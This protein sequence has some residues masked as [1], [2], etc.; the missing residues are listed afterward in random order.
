[1]FKTDEEAEFLLG[2][3]NNSVSH[4]TIG[5]G[6]HGNGGARS[7]S[8]EKIDSEARA[9]IG[10]LATLFGDKAA[11]E[12]TSKPRGYAT[13]FRNGQNLAGKPDESLERELIS[14]RGVIQEK[15]LEKADQFLEMLGIGSDLSDSMK[16]ASI[17]EKVVNI[18]E[19]LQPKTPSLNLQAAQIVFYAPKIKETNDYP[20]IEVEAQQG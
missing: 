11:G 2:H 8:Y 9:R 6:Q 20:I 10:V 13:K 17:A 1:M 3:A 19:K 18:Y 7:G 5:T 14:R 16:Q 4:K 12:L 15:A